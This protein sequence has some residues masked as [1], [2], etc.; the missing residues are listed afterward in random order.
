MK[1]QAFTDAKLKEKFSPER[2]ILDSEANTNIKTNFFPSL[3]VGI[4]QN[5]I[6]Q[7][8]CLY[9]SCWFHMKYDLMKT[10]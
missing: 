2:N 3:L 4:I 6:Y 1:D 5:R 7:N 8:S 9:I 10:I